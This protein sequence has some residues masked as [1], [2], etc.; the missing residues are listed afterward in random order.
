MGAQSGFCSPVL[1]P[2]VVDS[3]MVEARSWALQVWNTKTMSDM[4]VRRSRSS[5]HIFNPSRTVWEQVS[6]IHGS[7]WEPSNM[8][9][10]I[11]I[12]RREKAVLGSLQYMG[13]LV[14]LC[15]DHVIATNGFSSSNIRKKPQT[16]HE[17]IFIRTDKCYSFWLRKLILVCFQR[18]GK[19]LLWPAA[20]MEWLLKG[21]LSTAMVCT[22]QQEVSCPEISFGI[23]GHHWKSVLLLILKKHL[24][25]CFA[26]AL[27]VYPIKNTSI[28]ALGFLG[29][30]KGDRHAGALWLLAQI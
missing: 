7:S 10:Q 27:A 22:A 14:N 17:A 24:P 6:G 8:S 23:W 21:S 19:S 30:Y 9:C 4:D 25:T 16:S 26:A 11:N 29:G 15:K 20:P 18:G 28:T 2:L 1:V 13:T 3:K 12:M 5:Y